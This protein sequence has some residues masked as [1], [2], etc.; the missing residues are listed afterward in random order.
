MWQ[1]WGWGSERSNNLF[2]VSRLLSGRINSC[3][4]IIYPRACAFIRWTTP[5]TGYSCLRNCTSYLR[6]GIMVTG[7]TTVAQGLARQGQG[8]TW[9]SGLFSVRQEFSS[10]HTPSHLF[11][12]RHLSSKSASISSLEE[13]VADSEWESRSSLV[14]TFP[15]FYINGQG[16]RLSSSLQRTSILS[17]RI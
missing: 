15:S 1:S 13:P 11:G 3:I 8:H 6:H 7:L 17:G 12:C 4:Q 14:H 5:S 2:S 10:L 16:Y 9:A